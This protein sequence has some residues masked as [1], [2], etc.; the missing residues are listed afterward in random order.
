MVC[1]GDGQLPIAVEVQDACDELSQQGKER[2]GDP[3]K[4]QIPPCRCESHHRV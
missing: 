2:P 1:L 3:V 4:V